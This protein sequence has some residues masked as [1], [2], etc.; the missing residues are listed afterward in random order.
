MRAFFQ[1]TDR[2]RVQRS[3]WSASNHWL[4]SFVSVLVGWLSLTGIAQETFEPTRLRT[5][6]PPVHPARVVGWGQE[7]LR[8]SV[9]A[10]GRVGAVES[11]VQAPAFSN[12]LR[13]AVQGWSFVAARED[14]AAV[15]SAVLVVGVFRPAT[16]HDP[17]GLEGPTGVLLPGAG[18]PVPMA[19]PPPPYPSRTRGN[20]VA[21]VEAEVNRQGMVTEA[22]VVM[23]TQGFARVAL[24]T[25]RRWQFE[26]ATRRGRAVPSVVYF[27]FSFR[28]PVVIPHARP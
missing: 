17:P 8:V 11:V 1:A 27:V 2:R 7:W 5:G 18:I 20:G 14:G 21:L 6:A 3:L 16:L 13:Q 19:T 12:A 26:S 28:E 24:T 10:V 9:D 25:A 4:V 23:P 15:P 22:R